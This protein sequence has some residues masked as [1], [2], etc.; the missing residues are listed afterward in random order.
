MDETIEFAAENI[1]EPEKPRVVGGNVRGFYNICSM[2][3]E[4]RDAL[5]VSEYLNG[6]GGKR[7]L[8]GKSQIFNS[9]GEGW[10][11]PDC[12]MVDRLKNHKKYL[13]QD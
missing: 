9:V 12:K 13:V 4:G 2:E 11:Q 1:F 5:V 8:C 3:Y 10:E 6:E 7:T